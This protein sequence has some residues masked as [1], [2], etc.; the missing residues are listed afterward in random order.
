LPGAALENLGAREY[1][2][3][4]GRFLSADPVL[5]TAD[6]DQVNGYDYAGNNPITSSDP[7][8]TCVRIEDRNGPCASAMNTTAGQQ[9]LKQV[10][11]NQRHQEALWRA[12]EQQRHLAYLNFLRRTGEDRIEAADA[13]EAK[14]ARSKHHWYSGAVNWAEKHA[15]AIGTVAG[16]ATGVLCTIATGGAGAVACGALG[17]FVSSVATDGLNVAAGKEGWG[18]FGLD[19]FTGTVVG[20]VAG[21]VGAM[22]GGGVSGAIEAGV[23]D[24]G[25]GFIRGAVAAAKD[26]GPKAFAKSTRGLGQFVSG[27]IRNIGLEVA[28]IGVGGTINAISR[29]ILRGAASSNSITQGVVAGVTPMLTGSAFGHRDMIATIATGG[30]E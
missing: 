8:G 10:E 20:G 29:D 30:F 18:Q 2:A 6:P 13:A 9:R 7:N 22:L 23:E 28:D 19:V 14:A 1:D 17:G 3:V 12:W 24:A 4:T 15:S 26:L 5:E 21:G 25:G 27:S 11:A 16:I